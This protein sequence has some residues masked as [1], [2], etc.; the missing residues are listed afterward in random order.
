MNTVLTRT[1]SAT[2]ER[3]PTPVLAR[4]TDGRLWHGVDADARPV[5]VMRC[6]PWTEPARYVS[7][8]D[9]NDT[10][11][12]L[13]PDPA[14]L[15]ALS[16]EALEGA[17]A[18]AGFLLEVTGI[19]A[20]GEEV[21]V[22]HWSVDTRQGARRFQTGLEDWPRPLPGGGFLLRDVGGDLYR[23]PEPE[24]LDSSSQALLWAFID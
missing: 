9:D 5:T 4:G 10:E 7:L 21:E 1:R 20:V 24:D 13:V 18:E 23:I 2:T 17:L 6:F 14:E 11:V 12:A 15:D 22:R 8:R 19:L 3:Q 16:R